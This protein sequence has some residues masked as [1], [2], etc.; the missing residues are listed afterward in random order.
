MGKF[1]RDGRATMVCTFDDGTNSSA[2]RMFRL[3]YDKIEHFIFDEMF[4]RRKTR[5][6]GTDDDRSILFYAVRSFRG[7][8]SYDA[9]IITVITTSLAKRRLQSPVKAK[10]L[11][12]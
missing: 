9:V 6:A 11:R 7:H 5:N 10:C 12:L 4:S 1:G 3:E 8:L 2:D